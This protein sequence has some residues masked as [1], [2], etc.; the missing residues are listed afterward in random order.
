MKSLPAGSHSQLPSV[1][2]G[3]MWSTDLVLVQRAISLFTHSDWADEGEARSTN[4][5]L[6]SSA[7][8]MADH[9]SGFVDNPVSSA[10]DA[11]CPT[12]VPW[13]GEELESTLQG[14]REPAVG[15]MAI[16]NKSVVGQIALPRTSPAQV[17]QDP[18]AVSEEPQPHLGLFFS[19]G[20]PRPPSSGAPS[21]PRVPV[22]SFK[23]Q[24]AVD[25]CLECAWTRSGT[26]AT[27]RTS[28][29]W[30]NVRHSRSRDRHSLTPR[31]PLRRPLSRRRLRAA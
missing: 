30:A 1:T 3:K 17:C 9:K 29:P 14:G 19:L 2:T 27:D 7:P 15:R 11:Q 22:R 20:Y 24:I 28:W 31:G 13:L 21:E 5:S 4:H 12:T 8:S 18:T 16:R 10:K 25:C 6:S 26:C 23:H